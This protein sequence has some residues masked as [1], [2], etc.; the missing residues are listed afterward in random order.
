MKKSVPMTRSNSV[1]NCEPAM[2]GVPN[3]TSAEVAALA[4]TSRGMRQTV[5]PGARIVKIVTRKLIA[6]MIELAPA[7]WIPTSKSVWPVPP[8]VASGV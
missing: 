5:M 6:V 1:R 2:N 4:H 7:N 3:T 8:W